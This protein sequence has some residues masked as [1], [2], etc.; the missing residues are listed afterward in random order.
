M[1]EFT[2]EARREF[3]KCFDG[4]SDQVIAAAWVYAVGLTKF[5]ID[6]SKEWTTLTQKRSELDFAYRQGRHD[7]REKWRNAEEVAQ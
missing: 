1:V 2:E 6:L 4:F 5:G 7:E 3:I